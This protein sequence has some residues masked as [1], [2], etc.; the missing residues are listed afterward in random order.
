LRYTLAPAGQL[1]L[2]DGSLKSIS[3]ARQAQRLTVDASKTSAAQHVG[4]VGSFPQTEISKFQIARYQFAELKIELTFR[5]SSVR[6]FDRVAECDGRMDVAIARTG[7][8]HSKI[9]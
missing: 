2:G 1:T 3:S 8:L 4:G 5:Y 9:C 7:H 6:R